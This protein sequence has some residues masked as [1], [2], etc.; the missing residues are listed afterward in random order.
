MAVVTNMI[1]VS[2]MVIVILQRYIKIIA[3]DALP[4]PQIFVWLEAFLHN[5]WSLMISLP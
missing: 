3:Q 2:I 5:L 4:I 1:F